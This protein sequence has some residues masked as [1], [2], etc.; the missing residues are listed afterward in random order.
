MGGDGRAS[1][2]GK[3]QCPLC[4]NAAGYPRVLE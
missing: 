4:A 3:Y 2:L 1:E